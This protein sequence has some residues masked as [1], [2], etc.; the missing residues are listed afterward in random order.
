MYRGKTLFAQ[1]MSFLP[2]TTFARLVNRYQSDRRVRGFPF[3]EHFRALAFG[4][5]TRR[6]SLRGIA[7][8]LAARPAKLYHCGFRG[9]VQIAMLSRANQ[10]RD[11]RIHADFDQRLIARARMWSPTKRITHS[12]R[13]CIRLFPCRMTLDFG[14]LRACKCLIDKVLRTS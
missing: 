11:W 2:W 1:L 5:I 10:R 14:L 8:C 4:Q 7:A 12:D 3:T 13:E 9:R 6:Q